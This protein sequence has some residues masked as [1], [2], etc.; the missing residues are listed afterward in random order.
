MNDENPILSCA[1]A[2]KWERW[3]AKN[4]TKLNGIW[5]RI[6]KKGSGKVS[7]TYAEALD[8]ALCYGWIDGQKKSHDDLSWLQ[9]F[10]PRRPKGPWS[11]INT[12]H[13]G[14]LTNACRMKPAGLAAVEAAKRDGRWKR[15]YDSPSAATVPKDFQLE[16]GKNKV[17]KA[18]FATLNKTN[19]YAI[20]YRL[21]NAKKPETR[22]KRM[23]AILAMLE[24]GERFH[25]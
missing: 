18:F 21:Q 17:A 13:V 3:L 16:L 2:Q 19:T 23:K 11:K 25:P 6:F 24:K 14:R 5:L 22:E 12:Q 1:S 10:T 9:K 4:H 7:V 20:T 15:A 8:S